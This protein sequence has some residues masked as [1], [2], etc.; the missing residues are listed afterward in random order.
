MEKPTWQKSASFGLKIQVALLGISFLGIG[1]LVAFGLK[2]REALIDTKA[3]TVR[4]SSESILDKIDRNLFER[5]G[6]V[7]A[8]AVSVPARSM[9]PARLVPFINDMMGIYAPVYDLMVVANLEGKI[10]AANTVFKDGKP[11]AET[12]KILGQSVGEESWFKEAVAGKIAAGTAFVEDPIVDIL[13][14]KVWTDNRKSMRFTSPIIDPATQKII[15]VWS[16]RMSWKDVVDGIINEEILKLKSESFAY[17]M[18]ILM[19]SE[20]TPLS[21]PADLEKSELIKISPEQLKGILKE[22]SA[23]FETIGEVRTAQYS[24]EIVSGLAPSKGYSI[25]PARDWVFALK[26]NKSDP[27]I[28]ALVYMFVAILGAVFLANFLAFVFIRSKTK[29]ISGVIQKLDFVARDL[30]QQS[31]QLRDNSQHLAEAATEQAAALQETASALEQTKSMIQKTSDNVAQSRESAENVSKAVEKGGNSIRQV[32]TAV[33]G[34]ESTNKKMIQDILDG[35]KQVAGIVSLV[36]EISTKTKVINDIVFQTKLLSFNASVEAARAG[37]HG[38]GFAVVAEEVGNLA[39]M[40]GNAAREISTLIETSVTRI[41]E[42]VSGTQTRV[43]SVLKSAK[44]SVDLASKRAQESQEILNEIV[45]NVGD[46]SRMVQEIDMA[47]K[48]QA[49][50]VSEISKAMGQLDEVT[51]KNS[52]S[53]NVASSMAQKAGE[54]STELYKNLSVLTQEFIGSQK[55]SL[56]IVET[57][58]EPGEESLESSAEFESDQSRA[59]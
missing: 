32:A 9:D 44:E 56:P 49:T 46:M 7:Q 4:Q 42:I 52:S 36:N 31:L 50:G 8:F 21:Y 43:E 48:E 40:S 55:S 30:N 19:N 51:Q 20:G 22:K 33:S 28:K 17:L 24:G 59:A 23:V 58:N 1:G 57:S 3:K 35:N 54:K 10:V 16:N 53:S 6:D 13:T 38:K 26:V 45:S 27:A 15:G 14:E 5:Y 39:Q 18:P 34:I 12:S 11:L 2:T 37:E 41:N 29:L 47:S 25:Y